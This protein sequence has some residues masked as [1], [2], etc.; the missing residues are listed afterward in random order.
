M[1]YCD[2]KTPVRIE[3]GSEFVWKVRFYE[4]DYVLNLLTNEL[5]YKRTKLLSSVRR[6]WLGKTVAQCIWDLNV[7]LA[8]IPDHIHIPQEVNL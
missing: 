8:A 5:E 7:E 2:Y 6:R 4:G 3:N 1:L